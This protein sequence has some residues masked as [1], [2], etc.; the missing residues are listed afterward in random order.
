MSPVESMLHGTSLLGW[1]LCVWLLLANGQRSGA[2]AGMARLVLAL[3]LAMP[4]AT[5][6][7]ALRIL[8][9]AWPLP[10]AW[11]AAESAL[12]G[13]GVV[14]LVRRR[15]ARSV[16]V[17]S[18]WPWTLVVPAWVG[19]AAVAMAYSHSVYGAHDAWSMWL[20]R[21]NVLLRGSGEQAAFAA[22]LVDC[23]NS[24]YPLGH[25]LACYRLAAVTGLA[26]APA[27]ALANLFAV[28]GS[29]VL[30]AAAN[31]PRSA[32][33]LLL[34]A[35]G[36][37][38]RGFLRDAA[39]LYADVPVALLVAC[40]SACVIAPQRLRRAGIGPEWLLPLA[41]GALVWT[42]AEGLLHATVW[43]IAWVVRRD[44][45]SSWRRRVGA[46]GLC[47]LPFLVCRLVWAAG[48]APN[49]Y[50][51]ADRIGTMLALLGD[52]QRWLTAIGFVAGKLLSYCNGVLVVG[53]GCCLLLFRDRRRGW[54]HLARR[55]GLALLALAATGAVFLVVLVG[56]PYDEL[57][58]LLRQTVTRLLSQLLPALLLLLA[59]TL[60]APLR[61]AL[62]RQRP[63]G[64]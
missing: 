45:T 3:A 63:R 29:F 62:A 52:G 9:G 4:L 19:L 58:V 36:A 40:A 37:A 8:T 30:L 13:G 50:L 38:S 2:L 34:V 11:L 35:V 64:R 5:L 18:P 28:A 6:G 41:A 12:L 25:S 32:L 54:W 10:L 14:W 21:A 55:Q 33:A 57:P 47:L 20:Y 31:Q 42:K 49:E 15:R 61:A 22:I 26:S 23:P 53:A 17:R 39:D 59:A 16:R 48:A 51:G 46:L 43:S 24:G 1:C 44:P 56:S 7:P 60:Q 27:M